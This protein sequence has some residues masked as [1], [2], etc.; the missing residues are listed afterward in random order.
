MAGDRKQIPFLRTEFD[1]GWG[2]FS[3]DAHWIAYVS[4]ES[5]SFELYVRPFAAPESGSPGIAGKWQVSKG[6]ATTATPFWRADGKELYYRSPT[7]AL[8][9]VDV[10]AST[11]FQSGAPHRLFDVLAAAPVDAAADGKR[12]LAAM[13][14]QESG[15]QAITV[16][17]NWQASL[18]R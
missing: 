16:V 4:G 11:T 10:N 5:G 15:P 6:G 17:L 18:K 1:E 8:M 9:A 7:G 14:Q 2:A 3:P 13:P 12:F